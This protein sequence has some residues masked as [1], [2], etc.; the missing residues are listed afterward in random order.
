M[1]PDDLND[2]ENNAG[3]P[4]TWCYRVVVFGP[5]P[6]STSQYDWYN[7]YDPDADLADID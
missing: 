2:A 1:D 3:E 7:V 5:G 6:L 4:H